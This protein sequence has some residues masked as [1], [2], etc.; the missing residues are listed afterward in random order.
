[1]SAFLSSHVT[2]Q[3]AGYPTLD[4]L[5]KTTSGLP[6]WYSLLELGLPLPSDRMVAFFSVTSTLDGERKGESPERHRNY[7]MS[8]LMLPQHCCSS[9]C[10]PNLTLLRIFTWATFQFESRLDGCDSG[11]DGSIWHDRSVH[12]DFFGRGE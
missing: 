11:D 1:M 12:V 6:V 7:F 4:L 9:C 5:C 2:L 8:L 3:F 10:T